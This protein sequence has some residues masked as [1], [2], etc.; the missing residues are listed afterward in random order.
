MGTHSIC[1]GAATFASRFGLPKDWVNLCGRWRGKKKQ[2]NRY[3]N[4]DQPY[5][6]ACIAAVLCGSCGPCKYAVKDGMVIP[7]AFLD[8]I[9][10]HCY[11]AFGTEV[12]Q[13]LVLPLLWAALQYSAGRYVGQV[14]SHIHDY[15]SARQPTILIGILK[16]IGC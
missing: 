10:S 7:A 8:S 14:G 12:A 5:P 13:V 2:V 11:A 15:P 3:I 6:D 4:V 9:V 1:K 16:G